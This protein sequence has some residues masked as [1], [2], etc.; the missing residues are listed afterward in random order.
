MASI[1]VRDR[2]FK[3]Y[4]FKSEKIAF[5]FLL[6]KFDYLNYYV[7]SINKGLDWIDANQYYSSISNKYSESSDFK[8]KNRD[9]SHDKT[10]RTYVDNNMNQLL[11]KMND[12]DKQENKKKTEKKSESSSFSTFLF[13]IIIVIVGVAIYNNNNR[14]AKESSRSSIQN[15]NNQSIKSNSKN[16]NP[17]ESITNENSNTNNNSSDNKVNHSSGSET[18]TCLIC[19]GEGRYI[20][21]ECDGRGSKLCS[22]CNGNG[23]IE[24]RYNG[25]RRGC[26]K[27]LNKG[28]LNCDR[29]TVCGRN[30][31]FG[32]AL[33]G[34]GCDGKGYVDKERH[35]KQLE[36]QQTIEDATNQHN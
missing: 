13:I 26:N 16:S 28:V 11:N 30:F 29:Y 4:E 15:V 23:Y 31:S 18:F 8:K 14:S 7:V 9:N 3:K 21:N 6:K 24:D 12:F 20:C 33:M 19:N 10:L 2:N 36:M 5:E 32:T 27:C 1:F 34:G 25:T 17:S 22:T 35:E